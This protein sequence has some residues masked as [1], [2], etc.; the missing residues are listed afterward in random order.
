MFVRDLGLDSLTG[1]I[2]VVLELPVKR[3]AFEIGIP[4]EDAKIVPVS[5]EPIDIRTDNYQLI[6]QIEGGDYRTIDPGPETTYTGSVSGVEGSTVAASVLDGRLLLAMWMPD[7]TRRYVQPLSDFIPGA[8][9]SLHVV[10]KSGD[11]LCV[12]DCGNSFAQEVDRYRGGGGYDPR[13]LCSASYCE[14]VVATDA[15]FEYFQDHGSSSLE[16]QGRIAAVINVVNHQYQRDVQI[17]HRI[18]SQIVRS[19]SADPYT[20]TVPGTLLSEF[21]SFWNANHSGLARDVAHLFTGKNL[22]GSVIGIAYVGVICASLTTG[23]GY[24]LSQSDFSSSFACVSDLTAHEIGHNWDADHC[25]S[26][27]TSTMNPSITCVNAFTGSVGVNTITQI[28]AHADS[29]T[30]LTGVSVTPANNM[31]T[32]ATIITAYGTWTGSNVGATTD[33]SPQPC[34]SSTSSSA[35]GRNDVWWRFSPPANGT[36]TIDTCGSSFDTVLSVHTDCP[37]TPGNQ[38][39]CNDDTGSTNCPSNGLNSMVSF[40]GLAGR[41]YYIRVAGFSTNTGSITL[42][43]TG[44]ANPTESICGLAPVLVDGTTVFGSLLSTGNDGEATCGGANGSNRDVWYRFNAVC[45]GTLTMDTCGTH[46]F[47]SQDDGMD[48]VVSIHSACATDT[49]TQLACNDDS[50]VG[51]TQAGLIRD[52]NVSV[53]MTAGQSVWVR[54]THFGSHPPSVFSWGNGYFR[55]RT[56]FAESVTAPVINAI[57]NDSHNCGSSYTG[58]TPSVTLPS[59]MT[60]LTWT[61]VSGPAGMSINSS[62]GVV[63]W[64][65]PVL[66][67]HFINIRASNSDGSDTEAWTLSVNTISPVISPISDQNVPCAPAVY[68]GPTPSLTN[69]ACMA[70]V[71][72]S[73]AGSPSGM[74]VNP[75]TGVVSWPN[76]VGGSHGVRLVATNSVGADSEVFIVNINGVAPSFNSGP[77]SQS[78]TVGDTVNFIVSANGYPGVA[79]QWQYNGG[80]IVNGGRF[81]GA[82]GPMLTITNV[83]LSDAGGYRCIISNACGSRTSTTATLTVNTPPQCD[84]DYNQDG[85]VDQDDVLYLINVIGGAPNPTGRDPDFNCDGNADQDDITSLIDVVGGGTCPC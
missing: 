82:N 43:V 63:S 70:P 85:N 15:D 68:T 81:S 50:S 71:T 69:P 45:N 47:P 73:L 40:S 9:P 65:V 76:P 52:S 49:S 46:D 78:V 26:S 14:A 13:G 18:G 48:T 5:L 38:I 66:G 80:N 62:T 2:V 74:T 28:D 34:G 27:C 20:S 31:C 35:M 21:R 75:G 61:L 57:A 4:T 25:T 41:I 60:G 36:V 55:L 51:C 64:P 17:T 6:E 7:G 84:P 30:C 12:G 1:G 56:T 53:A 29:R 67:N 32:A 19:T 16:T 44:P 42:N 77:T 58:P 72:W 59:C 8:H 54:V 79:Y 23:S 83:Q 37:G 33:G 39:A 24:G 3:E 22:D 11:S 10:Y